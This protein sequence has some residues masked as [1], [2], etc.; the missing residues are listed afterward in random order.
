MFCVSC[1]NVKCI[2][3]AQFANTNVKGNTHSLKNFFYFSKKRLSYPR[4][5]SDQALKL[6]KYAL[7]ISY[8]P[9][10]LLMTPGL[11]YLKKISKPK[12]E[13]KNTRISIKRSFLFLSTH[14]T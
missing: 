10:H 2:L 9:L 12:H 13:I 11:V 5:D 3:L 8:I 1:R 4:M 14:L 7:K 6:K